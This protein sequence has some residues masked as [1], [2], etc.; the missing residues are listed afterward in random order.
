MILTF[1]QTSLIPLWIIIGYLALLL[2]LGVISSRFFKGTAADYFVVSRSVGSFLLLM[3]VFG[4]TMTGFALVGSTGEAFAK[5]V[6][7]YGLMASWS[8]LV[9]SGVFFLVGI[10]LWAVGKRNG[11]MTQCEYFS[12]R[13]ES[14]SLGYLLFAILVL[15]L[16]PYLLVGVIAS[17]RFLQATTAGMFPETFAMTLPNGNPH[18]LTGSLPLWLGSLVVCGV[19][20]G[21]VFFGGL[22]GAVWANTFQTIV[23]MVTGVIAFY[24]IAQKFG[25]LQAATA[26]L[27]ASEN[28]E[29]AARGSQMG[30][31]QF[32]TY[33]FVPLS[34]G[35]FPHLFQ[36]W[37]TA[38]SAKSFRLTVVAHPIFI[39]VVWVPCILIG[40]WAAGLFADGGLRLPKNPDGTP[41]SNAVLGAMINQLV[42]SN[43]LS[44][45][46]G[47]GV[48]A[49]I[50]SS[51]DSQFVCLGTMFTNDIVIRLAGRDRL[52]DT[53]KI[54]ISRAFILTIVG[55]TYGLAV[56]MMGDDR[57]SQSVFALG[58]WC[59]SGFAALFPLVFAAVYWRRTTK[60][61]ALACVLV[62]TV[63]WSVLFYR[64]IFAEKAPGSEEEKL[65]FGMMPVA[66]IFAASAVTLVVVS[67]I[68]RPLSTATINK[69]FDPLE[70]N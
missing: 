54:W 5:G 31:L 13:F 68:T 3:S 50:M 43:V 2:G 10:R 49:A 24:L 25:G 48:L 26:K 9:H 35:M 6:G 11:Y 36:H 39:A 52:T 41:I 27:L 30:P 46:V 1:A 55:V 60:A 29:R 38:R 4:T 51:L 45:L 34:V 47:A 69:F 8:G 37:L 44:G 21:Y 64:D 70:T 40:V 42:H 67:L 28:A 14:R 19:V 57:R 58:V 20:L 32:F 15:L 23:F 56:Y 53:Q 65:I 17:G 7:V 66:I 59:F 62:T 22:R 63:V 61:G 16:I 18:P 33:C 12:D